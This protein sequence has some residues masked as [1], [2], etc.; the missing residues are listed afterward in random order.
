MNYSNAIKIISRYLKNNFR[1][2][3]IRK[4]LSKFAYT[5]VIV[6]DGRKYIIKLLE[7]RNVVSNILHSKQHIGSIVAA[8]K[9]IN[10]D[11]NIKTISIID[12]LC[13][14]KYSI[15]LI[16]KEEISKLDIK[17]ASDFK[18]LGKAILSFHSSCNL[19]RLQKLAWDNFP[20]HFISILKKHGRWNAIKQFLNKN[21]RYI[22]TKN[23]T[24]CHNDIHDGNIY[25][26]DKKIIFLDIDDMCKNYYFSDLG[27]AVANFTNSSYSKPKLLKAIKSLLSGYNKKHSPTNIR[28]VAL[29]ALRKS[30]FTEAYYLYANKINGGSLKIVP[31]LRKRQKLLSN[32]VEDYL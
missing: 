14:K 25:V 12:F 18:I 30:Y 17:R 9:K 19:I 27:M 23:I 26:C 24:T 31:E 8:S 13:R 28:N 2:F 15:L 10:D 6:A 29:F 5:F 32:F 11:G 22:D 16:R 20:S 3:E 7:Y 1:V 21:E 4:R